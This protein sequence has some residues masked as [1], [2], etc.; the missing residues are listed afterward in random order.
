[1]NRIIPLHVRK[2]DADEWLA[3]AIDN[4]IA[5][6]ICAWVKQF[7]H[8]MA[9]Y[10]DEAQADNPYIF[11]PKK[12]QM[13]FVSPRSLERVSNIVKVRHKLD[14][15]SLICAMS[16]AVGESASRDM[17]AYIEFSDQLPT[18]ESVI[19]NPKTA[20]VPEGA[21]ACAIIVFGAIAKV[22]KTTMP[23][24]M[25][26]LERFEPEW[27][28]CFAINIAKSSAK[29]AIAFSSMKF[30]DWVQKNEDLL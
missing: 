22:D 1:M 26:Y 9:S 24:F 12:V 5:P 10:L 27:Q 16:G 25:D 11:N 14:T 20:K 18:W 19:D 8:S 23:K 29:Q 13:A 2:P 28:A 7:P 21:G 4:D 30:A 3:W 6:E 15:D 17:Q